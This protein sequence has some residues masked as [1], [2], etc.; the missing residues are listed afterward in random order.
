MK[1]N[2]ESNLESNSEPIHPIAA[3]FKRIYQPR[4][5][6]G[7]LICYATLIFCITG[8]AILDELGVWQ[9]AVITCLCLVWIALFWGSAS[10]K[11]YHNF[12]KN[13]SRYKEVDSLYT[14]HR[15][16]SSSSF[17]VFFAPIAVYIWIH[18]TLPDYAL[19]VAYVEYSSQIHE[20][21]VGVDYYEV[22]Q[23]DV[24]LGSF[25]WFWAK[26]Q[27]KSR[28]K[29]VEVTGIV[30]LERRDQGETSYL[31]SRSYSSPRGRVRASQ[32]SK[33]RDQLYR[34]ARAELTSTSRFEIKCL[35]RLRASNK[36]RQHLKAMQSG[37]GADAPSRAL[38]LQEVRD[39]ELSLIHI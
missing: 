11:R 2:L 24:S 4:L 8:R 17:F 10:S 37:W 33:I 35:K 23:V 39:W 27:H 29:A 28:I 20:R 14:H 7:Q 19:N 36:R 34:R 1:L 22:D 3:E 18:T 31:Y 6:F 15:R 38:F 21:D 13:D 32:V 9:G 12:G 26:D 5:I 30:E 25:H 16:H